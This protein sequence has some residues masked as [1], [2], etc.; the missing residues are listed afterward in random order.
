MDS[1]NILKVE[2]KISYVGQKSE[3]KGETKYDS[4]ASGLNDWIEYIIT[5]TEETGRGVV[6]R[7][8][9]RNLDQCLAHRRHAINGNYYRQLVILYSVSTASRKQRESVTS[10]F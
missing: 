9:M 8:G 10:L 7:P 5:E 4:Q 2:S 6:F 3:E 1:R